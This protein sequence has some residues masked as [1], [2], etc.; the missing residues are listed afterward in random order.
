MLRGR[1]VI[2]ILWSPKDKEAK[3]EC[4]P[5]LDGKYPINEEDL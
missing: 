3:N 5:N 4:S 2:V 1:Q